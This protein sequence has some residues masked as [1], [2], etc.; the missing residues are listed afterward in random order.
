MLARI[1]APRPFGRLA[2]HLAGVLGGCL[3]ALGAVLP[4]G[5]SAALAA[6]SAPTDHVGWATRGPVD[7]GGTRRLVFQVR[8]PGTASAPVLVDI[9]MPAMAMHVPA[10]T[11][12]AL[13]GGRYAVRLSVAMAGAWQ[14]RVTVGAPGHRITRVIPFTALPGTPTPWRLAGGVVG[15]ILILTGLLLYRMRR[16][17]PAFIEPIP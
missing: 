7:A 6:T 4:L 11:A 5:A 13:G 9:A 10:V 2:R 15:A 3:V 1:V 17:G 16:A 12:T 14:A 8:G